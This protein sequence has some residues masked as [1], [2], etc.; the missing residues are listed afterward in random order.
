MKIKQLPLL[1]LFFCLIVTVQAEAG[2]Q[3]TISPIYLQDFMR[4]DAETDY[5][6]HGP[7]INVSFIR[8]GALDLNFS[9]TAGIPVVLSENG[10]TAIS[11]DYYSNPASIHLLAGP[12]WSFPMGEIMIFEPS[13][14]LQAGFINLKGTGYSSLQFA[15]LGIGTELR[16]KARINPKLMLGM[17]TGFNWNIID[18]QHFS[19]HDIGYSMSAGITAGFEFE[20]GRVK[21]SRRNE[22]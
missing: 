15:P 7:G 11:Y 12:V 13:L 6:F 10:S 16:L 19:D 14:G 22:E 9:V 1:I 5:R 3:F 20:S 18:M 8:D 21:K 17:M 4:N 2:D